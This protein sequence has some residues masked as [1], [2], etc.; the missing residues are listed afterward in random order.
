M[1]QLWQP[2]VTVWQGKLKADTSKV[3]LD[4]CDLF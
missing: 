3:E 1:G 4:T 2:I